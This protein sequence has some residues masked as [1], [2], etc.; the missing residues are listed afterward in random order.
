MNPYFVLLSFVF[1]IGTVLSSANPPFDYVWGTAHHVLPETHSE[2]SGYFSLCEGNDGRIFIGTSKYDHNAYLVE[3]DPVTEKQRVVVDAHKVCGLTAKGYAAQAK[4]HTRNYVGPSGIIYA[5][6][7]QGYAKKG[8][9]SEYPGGYLITYDPRN[10]TARNLGMPYEKQG[11]ADVVAD[12]S[13]GLIYVVTCEEQHWML[14]DTE[15]KK[16]TELGPM[17]TPYATTL[18]DAEGKAHALTKDFQLATYDPA[19]KKVSL[20]P[21]EVG[22]KIFERASRSSIPT[23]NLDADGRTAWLILMNDA[24]LLSIELSSK[25]KRAMGTNH[26]LMLKGERPDS[27][28]ALTIAPDGRIYALISVQNT[29]GFGKGKLHHLCRYDPKKRRHEDLG[30]LAVKNPDFFDFEP[31]NGKKPPWS[32]GYHTLPDGTMT[33]LHNHMALI[34]TRDNTL[35]ATIIYPFTLLKIDAFRTEPPAPR[36][37]QKYLRSIHQ[38]LDR[39]EKNLPQFT[40]LGERTAERYER[41]GLVGF[42]WL[43]ATLE[44]ELIGRSGGLM[45]VGFDRPWK[46]KALRTDKEKAHDMAVL[47]W[48]TDPKPNDFKRL[49]KFKEAGQFVL[50]FGSMRNPRLADHAEACD[51][52]V[53][54]DTEPKDRDPGKLNHV[55][56]AVSGWVWMA[57]TIAAHTRK[58]RM[59]TMWKSWAMEDGRDWSD[60]FF[61]KVKYHEDYSVAPISKGVLGKAFLHRIRS[62]LLALENTQLPTLLNFAESIARE[63]KAGRRTVVASSGH[64]VMHYVGKYSDSA[65]AD[66]IEVHEN[67]ESQLNN[68]KKKAPPGGLVLRLGYFGLSPKVD[69]L[70]KAKKSR[71]LLM[72]AENPRSDFASHLNYPGRLD[73]GLAFGDACVPIEGYPIALFPPSGIVKA[74][75]Y[76]SL[77]LEVLRLLGK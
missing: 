36:P 9:T 49:Q 6:T 58:G 62:Q 71:V 46:D 24:H 34:A 18:M 12:E 5:G 64:M 77:N 30:V 19:T 43:G 69:D 31:A 16:F 25:G 70:F 72:A 39:I 65:W 42:H 7:K 45:H 75:A 28:S 54:L 20:R 22:G 3:F 50:G 15:T 63:S 59:P 60:R 11:I 57:E 47:A 38:H 2:E 44:Q 68:F 4:F 21:I 37:A 23:W 13:R 73:L 27:R 41:G 35:Y 48:D 51:A 40:E 53:D 17:L 66:N 56:G 8:D 52:W 14:Y 32:H 1:L 67:V 10:D 61:R 26:G 33:P 55:V 74:A 29:T 76:E